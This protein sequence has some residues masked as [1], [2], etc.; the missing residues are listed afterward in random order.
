[1]QAPDLPF[2]LKQINWSIIWYNGFQGIEYQAIKDSDPWEMGN[3]W[4][5]SYN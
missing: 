3:K 2:H 4:S 1:M 5:E